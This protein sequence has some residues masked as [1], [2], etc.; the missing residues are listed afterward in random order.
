MYRIYY[1]GRP[2]I[3][4]GTLECVQDY[5]YNFMSQ[6][7]DEMDD[8]FYKKAH[9]TGANWSQEMDRWVAIPAYQYEVNVL[10][11]IRDNLFIIKEVED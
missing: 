8:T 7:L 6:I 11:G 1:K 10:Y 3:L 2:T 4:D 9:W 5:A